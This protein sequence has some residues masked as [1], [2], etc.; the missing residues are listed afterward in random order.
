MKLNGKRY[1]LYRN[2]LFSVSFS[3]LENT[4]VARLLHG[5]SLTSCTQIVFITVFYLDSLEYADSIACIG[6][7]IIIMVITITICSERGETINHVISECSKFAQKEKIRHNW[8]GK[9]IHLELRLKLKFHD[10]NK[11][12]IHSSGS[13]LRNET[14]FA[15]GFW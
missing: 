9:L 10:T 14:K 7:V 12:H 15:L 13:I 1:Y 11:W 3:A 4:D 8:L 5:P 2:Y 6:R